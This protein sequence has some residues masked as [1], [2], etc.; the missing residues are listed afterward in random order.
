MKVILLCA[1]FGTRLAPLTHDCPKPLLR[2]AGRPVLDY[3][4]DQLIHLPELDSI[5]VVSNRTHAP[6]Y[7][8]WIREWTAAHRAIGGRMHLHDD[9]ATDNHSRLGAARD[10]A[11]ALDAAGVP[12]RAFVASGDNILRFSLEPVWRRFLDAGL[13]LIL[14]L[15]E[16]DPKRLRERGVLRLGEGNRVV[17]L[18]EKSDRPASHW[19]C[20]ALYFLTAEALGLIHPFMQEAPDTDA[21]GHFIGYVARRIP[22][23][24]YPVQGG[25]LHIGSPKS[26]H[27]ADA[28]LSHEPVIVC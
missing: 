17:D 25:T 10:L 28:L 23:H 16:N 4:L 22:V 2:V 18:E 3:L 20:P 8:A 19:V 5:H 15:P 12:D 13:P 1:G 7:R 24:A 11:F 14:A 26:F 21:I 6:R 27:E 9:G